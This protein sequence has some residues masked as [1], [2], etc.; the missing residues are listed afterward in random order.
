MWTTQLEES[1]VH[2]HNYRESITMLVVQDGI[3]NTSDS[4]KDSDTERTQPMQMNR[5]SQ[6][7]DQEKEALLKQQQ[8][9]ANIEAARVFLK[10]GENRDSVGTIMSDRSSFD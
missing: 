3:N 4:E 2:E 8:Y 5:R 10:M 6:F 1:L 7:M 9:Y